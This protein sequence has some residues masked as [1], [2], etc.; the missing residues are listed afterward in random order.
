M[1]GATFVSGFDASA[2][3]PAVELGTSATNIVSHSV[4]P[5]TLSARGKGQVVGS[6]SSDDPEESDSERPASPAWHS[7]PY[8]HLLLIEDLMRDSLSLPCHVKINRIVRDLSNSVTMLAA[9]DVAK[10]S[11]DEELESTR[12]KLRR[13]E[14]ELEDQKKLIAELQT[15]VRG[16]HSHAETYKIRVV[17]LENDV[18]SWDVTIAELRQIVDVLEQ[19][20][21]DIKVSLSLEQAEIL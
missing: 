2:F 8:A 10:L 15:V 3:V 14:G 4:M 7:R 16:V 6:S 9:L 18:A 19:G 20:H 5:P 13:L 21:V 12:P 11:H 1:L 17:D